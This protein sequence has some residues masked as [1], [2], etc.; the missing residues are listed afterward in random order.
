M[1]EPLGVDQRTPDLVADEE[2][3]ELAHALRSGIDAMR[4][5]ARAY[6]WTLPNAGEQEAVDIP[7]NAG[8]YMTGFEKRILSTDLLDVWQRTIRATARLPFRNA[9]KYSDWDP[10]LVGLPATETQA[11]SPG[12]IQSI[13]KDGETF[14]AYAQ[15]MFEQALFDGISFSLVDNDPRTFAS[16]AERIAAKARP[17]VVSLKRR[18]L[19]WLE[20]ELTPSGE[21]RLKAIC[22]RQPEVGESTVDTASGQ[23]HCGCDETRKVVLAGYPAAPG[24][25]E[26]P[27]R[28]YVYAVGK[29]ADGSEDWTEIPGRRAFIKPDNPTDRLYDIPLV[30]HYGQRTAPWRGHSP[31]LGTAETA[32]VL[33][34][35]RSRLIS[36]GQEAS[37]IHFHESGVAIPGDNKSGDKLPG[38]LHSTYHQTTDPNGK[39]S[40]HE[41][42]GKSG[43]FLMKL[44]DMLERNIERAHAR[45]SAEKTAGPVTATEINLVGVEAS[46]ELEGRVI[47]QEAAWD[48]IFG[49]LALLAGH[50][51]R[52]GTVT[53]PHDFGLPSSEMEI[54]Q[55]DFLAGL[56]SPRAYVEEKERN[57]LYK[58]GFDKER[59]IA[60]LEAAI[61]RQNGIGT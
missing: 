56:M 6:R 23:L 58:D 30:P 50:S 61:E 31:Y 45:L 49:Y 18:D 48:K 28:T 21:I 16:A 5:A 27:V 57:G 3:H 34:D 12:W 17:Y 47:L 55:A 38:V 14:A 10:A 59:E 60:W 20:T 40:I 1:G 4:E 15:R 7:N 32:R 2:Q 39:F 26:L 29:K 52:N 37:E 43:A 46:S 24:Q 54:N 13:T 41:I 53:I 33:W 8:G 51:K 22:F 11:F 19:R 9:I 44:C 36:M 25:P 42:E 35:I